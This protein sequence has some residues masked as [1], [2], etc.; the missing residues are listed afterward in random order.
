MTRD[1]P[2]RHTSCIIF[3]DN[4]FDS[5]Y[6]FF[7]DV[8][9]VCLASARLF[10]I[11]LLKCVDKSPNLASFVHCS[12]SPLP[13]I[14]PGMPEAAWPCLEL[15]CLVLPCIAL[16]RLALPSPALPSLDLAYPSLAL[17]YLA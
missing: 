1:A 14:P 8:Q 15:P 3:Y 11:F 17:P 2:C 9:V 10:D 4:E 7:H 13:C 16:P 6:I 12:W 5:A